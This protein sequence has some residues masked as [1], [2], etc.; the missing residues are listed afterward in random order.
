MNEQMNAL[1]NEA[2]KAQC[3]EDNGQVVDNSQAILGR[4]AE[5]IVRECVHIAYNKMAVQKRDGIQPSA[6]CDAIK[7]HFGVEE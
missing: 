3:L 2:V 7:E 5:L 6:V 4:F 1:F